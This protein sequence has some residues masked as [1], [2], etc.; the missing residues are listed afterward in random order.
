VDSFLGFKVIRTEL[1]PVAS[2]VRSCI[3]YQRNSAVLVDGGR[4]TY[5]DILPQNRHSLQIR[6]TAVMGAT[7][8]LEKGVVEILADTTR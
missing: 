2:N 4:K 6:S 1:L 8:L 7:R 5:M 3:A